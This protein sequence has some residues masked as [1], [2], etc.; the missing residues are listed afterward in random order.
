MDQITSTS[1]EVVYTFFEKG[2]KKVEVS[3]S[4]CWISDDF[5]LSRLPIRQQGG[6]TVTI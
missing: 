3:F 2:L 6:E 4:E 5:T 1:L